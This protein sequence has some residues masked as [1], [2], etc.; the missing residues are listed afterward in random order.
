M[1][2]GL[3]TTSLELA[4]SGGIFDGI[5]HY[6]EQL[7]RGLVKAGL[8][9]SNY[10]FARPVARSGQRL[11]FSAPIRG[12]FA[13]LGAAGIASGG[14]ARLFAPPVDVFHSTDFKVVPA[15]CPVV[16]TIWD[17]I[18]LVHPEWI[19]P[20]SRGLVPRAIR[21]VAHF[22][23]R[24]ICATEHAAGDIVAHFGIAASRISIVPW[25]VPAEW[26]EPIP[27]PEVAAVLARY[28]IEPGYILT[29]GTIQ[30]RKNLARLIEA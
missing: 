15:R 12:G 24:I 5:A 26:L 8:D 25:G 2:L 29:V 17:A 6:T 23:D 27:A 1:K 4:A 20:R 18:P 16:A 3:S 13:L 22:A 9:V 28:G 7:G 11:R 21:R 19:P 30:P 14:A 10:A